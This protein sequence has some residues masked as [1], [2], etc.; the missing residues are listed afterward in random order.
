MAPRPTDSA[1]SYLEGVNQAA[2]MG[3][4]GQLV[5]RGSREEQQSMQAQPPLTG[6]LCASSVT[7]SRRARERWTASL[8]H[9]PTLGVAGLHSGGG[10]LLHRD[11]AV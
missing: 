5:D 6:Q 2:R 8:S 10:G 1:F 9:Q 11:G 3:P 4:P 7:Q